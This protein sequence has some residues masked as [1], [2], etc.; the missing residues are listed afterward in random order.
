MLD[1]ICER[2]ANYNM[3]FLNIDGAKKPEEIEVKKIECIKKSLKLD[4]IILEPGRYLVG[5]CIDMETRITKISNIQNKKI[6][7]IK[8]GIYSGFIDIL[9]YNRKF[10]IYFKTRKN[11]KVLLSYEKTNECDYE[12]AI[13]GGSS[14][15]GDRVG[16][17]FINSKYKD[18][19]IVG[20]KFY[21]KNVGAYFEEFFMPLGGDLIKKYN[22]V[23]SVDF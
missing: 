16:M 5:N 12:F 2:F 13:C 19:L 11:E 8:N 23:K 22:I 20:A 3:T 18:E 1:F 10:E 7:V 21:I 6:V 4:T 17:F 15:S 9:L 14:D